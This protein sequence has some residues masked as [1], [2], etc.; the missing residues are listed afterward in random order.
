LV[1]AVVSLQGGSMLTG[2]KLC[3]TQLLTTPR[4]CHALIMEGPT[5]SRIIA[6]QELDRCCPADVEYEQY[7]THAAPPRRWQC[8]R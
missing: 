1:A 7:V 3:D 2:R 5:S 4:P 8:E 6:D